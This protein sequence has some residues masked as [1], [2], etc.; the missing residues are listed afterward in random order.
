MQPKLKS[1]L[2]SGSLVMILLIM[3]LSILMTFISG[4][5]EKE[6]RDQ[7]RAFAK[8]STDY[9]ISN[10]KY[11]YKS[12]FDSVSYIGEGEYEGEKIYFA[13]DTKGQVLER[14]AHTKIDPLA[15]LAFASKS[16]TFE[17]P[18][19]QIAFYKGKFVVDVIE[20]KRE[21]LLDIEKYSVIL[22]VETGV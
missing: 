7:V 1:I 14:I 2:L 20:Q 18:R 5:L 19:V 17:S 4:P 8:I 13:C 3:L 6:H 15:A 21:T 9:R 16:L 10:P 22:T 11:L 12:S